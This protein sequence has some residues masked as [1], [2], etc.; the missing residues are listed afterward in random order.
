MQRNMPLRSH[1]PCDRQGAFL[2]LIV[3]FAAII[4]TGLK[5]VFWSVRAAEIRIMQWKVTPVQWKGSFVQWKA[6]RSAVE[7]W[8]S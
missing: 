3:E 2:Q 6:S 5:S 7:S 4:C 8:S 1:A